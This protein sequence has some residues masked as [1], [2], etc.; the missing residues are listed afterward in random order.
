[1]NHLNVELSKGEPT[2]DDGLG[3]S[4]GRRLEDLEAEVIKT[5][6]S[7]DG[8][9]AILLEDADAGTT[10]SLLLDETDA[11]AIADSLAAIVGERRRA[12]STRGFPIG[13]DE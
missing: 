12:D 8:D 6:P 7:T 5:A 13:G 4:I 1:M 10:V 2:A 11:E 9:V 3:L